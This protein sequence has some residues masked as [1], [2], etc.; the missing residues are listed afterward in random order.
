MISRTVTSNWLVSWLEAVDSWKVERKLSELRS[1]CIESANIG[2][3]SY[4]I[5]N[6]NLF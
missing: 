6:I 4:M 3:V 5:V 2:A 1:A